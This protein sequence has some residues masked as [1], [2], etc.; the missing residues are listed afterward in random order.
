MQFSHPALY[1]AA[2]PDPAWLPHPSPDT[3]ACM[4]KLKPAKGKAKRA[5]LRPE[6]ISCIVLVIAGF[7]LGML[8][9]YF[10]MKNANG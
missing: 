4:A 6:G 9:I 3:I 8:F 5:R 2:A 7:A 1:N 10:V